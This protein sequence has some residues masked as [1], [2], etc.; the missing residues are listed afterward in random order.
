MRSPKPSARPAARRR[1]P[2]QSPRRRLADIR[3][4]APAS[5]PGGNPQGRRDARLLKW[6]GRSARQACGARRRAP[7]EA[8]RADARLHSRGCWASSRKSIM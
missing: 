2:L 6:D 4:V 1:Q 3:L 8:R 5:A 7:R